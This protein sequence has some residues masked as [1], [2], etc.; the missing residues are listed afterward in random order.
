M[1][2]RL[3]RLF[4]LR[5]ERD[6]EVD[7]QTEA[8]RAEIEEFIREHQLPMNCADFIEGTSDAYK[9]WRRNPH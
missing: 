8:E 1:D 3:E 7:D 5:E 2:P 4:R 6:M 9:R